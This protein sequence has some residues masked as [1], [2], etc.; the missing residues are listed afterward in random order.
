MRW[1]D[2]IVEGSENTWGSKLLNLVTD[3][4]MTRWVQGGTRLRG[5]DQLSRL[6]LI[7][8]E[9]VEFAEGVSH[10]C[11]LG[12]SDHEQLVIKTW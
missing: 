8:T 10:K 7:S 6:Y 11:P 2:L 4:L 3:N 9:K 12:K 1:K 5:D